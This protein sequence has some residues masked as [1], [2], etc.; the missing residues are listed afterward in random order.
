[1]H[2]LS[3]E[4]STALG[5]FCLLVVAFCAYSY[6]FM[7]KLGVYCREAVEWVQLQNKN[8]VSL[9]RMAEVESTLTDL[10]EAYSTLLEGHKKLRSRIGMR[11]LRDRKENEAD[12]APGAA[13]SDRL[14]FKN[15][16]RLAAKSKGLLR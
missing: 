14:A 3:T 6:H 16:L 8:A 10:T 2:E 5:L 11:E 7:H 1:M 15:Q 4:L 9:R 12:L 13:D